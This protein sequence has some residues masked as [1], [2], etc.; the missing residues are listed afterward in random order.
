MIETIKK[1]IKKYLENNR[2]RDISEKN[3]KEAEFYHS[4]LKRLI[5]ILSNHEWRE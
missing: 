5:S 1:I 4:E 2:Y 3:A